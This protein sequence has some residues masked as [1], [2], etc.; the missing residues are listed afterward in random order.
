MTL[1]RQIPLLAYPSAVHSQ[2]PYQPAWEHEM[3]QLERI[4]SY[5][6]SGRWFRRTNKGGHFSI[7]GHFYRTCW[8]WHSQTVE[9]TFDA[10]TV[11][12]ICTLEGGTEPP[13]R[14]PLQ[15]LSVAEL[16]GELSVFQRLPDFQLSLPW[17]ADTWRSLA[18]AELLAA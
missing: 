12:L 5:L 17:S 18:Y 16:M 4:Y 7:G 15:G 14:V 10:Q 3:L 9:I 6:A 8:R 1:D 11:S 13:M 2:R